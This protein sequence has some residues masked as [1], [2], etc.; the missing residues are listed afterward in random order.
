LMAVRVTPPSPQWRLPRC[1]ASSSPV[2]CRKNSK[3]QLQQ[4]RAM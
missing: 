4:Q 2:A 1:A 3:G